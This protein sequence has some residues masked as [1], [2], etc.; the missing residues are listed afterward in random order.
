MKKTTAEEVLN[1]FAEEGSSKEEPAVN[2]LAQVI[3]DIV[4][5]DY[6]IELAKQEIEDQQG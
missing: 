4:N 5:G 2:E 3:A 1:W 6:S